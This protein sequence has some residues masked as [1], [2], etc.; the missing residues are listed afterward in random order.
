MSLANDTVSRF[1]GRVE[2]YVR[3]RPGYPNSVIDVICA[4]WSITNDRIVADIGCGPGMSTDVFLRASFRVIGIEPNQEMREAAEIRFANN[5]RFTS[6]P[7]TAEAT[8][9]TDHSVDIVVAAQA[10]HWFDVP[11]ARREFARIL[12]PPGMVV[13]LWNTL[14]T[15]TP[16]LRAYEDLLQRYAIDYRQV[17]HKNVGDEVFRVMFPN[18][19]KTVVLENVQSLDLAGVKGRLR[20]SSFAP[21][22]GHANFEPMMAAVKQL[23]DRHQVDGQVRF[24]YD[25][26]VYLGLVEPT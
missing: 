1:S 26:E 4:L 19:W 2:D 23:F 14:R 16:F 5:P 25:T 12:R 8:T 7:G 15:D 3:Y 17:H 6:V 21:T 13:L 9:L 18:G 10:F 22:E 11:S 24:E 20:S